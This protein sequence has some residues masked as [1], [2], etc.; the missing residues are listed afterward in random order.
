MELQTY[1]QRKVMSM[2]QIYSETDNQRQVSRFTVVGDVV[3]DEIAEY[4]NNMDSA[5]LKQLAIWDMT[6]AHWHQISTA[7]LLSH[8]DAARAFDFPGKRTAF[9]FSSDADYGVGRMLESYASARDFVGGLRSFRDL[10]RA[11]AWLFGGD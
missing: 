7:K 11:E 4:L 6:K 3:S 10:A 9:V 8:V 5:R 1:Q 2:A